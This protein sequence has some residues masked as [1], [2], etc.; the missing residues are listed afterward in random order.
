MY[1]AVCSV[2]VADSRSSVGLQ[3]DFWRDGD[4]RDDGNGR[5]LPRDI[6]YCP[7][8]VSFP[9]TIR[10]YF[11]SV[12]RSTYRKGEGCISYSN[13]R[14]LSSIPTVPTPSFP[15]SPSSG[16]H[17]ISGNAQ[18][19]CLPAKEIQKHPPLLQIL[20][21]ANIKTICHAVARGARQSRL[22]RPWRWTYW[23]GIR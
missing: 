1:A 7:G 22:S 15:L 3:M 23:L 13:P 10:K 6:L 21:S 2:M 18:P 19:H 14:P 20:P 8:R 9:L 16:I 11:Y 12:Q 4:A 17:I 5:C